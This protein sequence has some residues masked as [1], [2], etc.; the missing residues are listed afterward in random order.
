MVD[1]V[2]RYEY[3]VCSIAGCG[4]PGHQD[5]PRQLCKMNCP[6]G[7]AL[8]NH[9]GIW[10]SDR[11]NHCV[12][13]LPGSDEKPPPGKEDDMETIAGRPR[14]AGLRDGRGRDAQFYEPG[15]IACGKDGK[16]YVV[17]RENHC[18]R[19]ITCER[20]Q[21]Y[22]KN[23]CGSAR[24][25]S[26]FREGEA[27]QALFKRPFGITCATDGTFFV[28]DVGNDAVRRLNG[29]YACMYACLHVYMYVCVLVCVCVYAC[30]NMHTYASVCV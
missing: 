28:T 1:P 10:I 17:D 22:V 11:Q 4:L 8:D 29:M 20:G 30:N 12:R 27:G 25:E 19:S 14:K 15:G 7:V 9:D 26:G 23:V 16:M 3:I 24:G 6:S 18:I 13:R 5:G 21:G 2:A